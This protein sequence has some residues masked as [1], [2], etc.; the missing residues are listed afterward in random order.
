MIVG[1]KRKVGAVCD[2]FPLEEKNIKRFKSL[3]TPG[4][5]RRGA[6]SSTEEEPECFQLKIR[7]IDEELPRD[8]N[9]KNLLQESLHMY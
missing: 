6:K 3:M 9:G 4:T 7:T 8:S 1:R 2:T 5:D